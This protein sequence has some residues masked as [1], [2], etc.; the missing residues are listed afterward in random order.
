MALANPPSPLNG[1]SHE[2]FPFSFCDP[3]PNHHTNSKRNLS[4]FMNQQTS[5]QWT[6]KGDQLNCSLI[7]SPSLDTLTFSENN[8]LPADTY[9]LY[10]LYCSCKKNGWTSGGGASIFRNYV[11]FRGKVLYFLIFMRP[12]QTVATTVLF[13]LNIEVW[14][15]FL[16]KVAGG[17]QAIKSWNFLFPFVAERAKRALIKKSSRESP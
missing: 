7:P 17:D 13:A 2:Q 14:P 3:L 6:E 15:R 16:L 1:K 8:S 11:P 9:N 5:I 4:S 12:W 10:N